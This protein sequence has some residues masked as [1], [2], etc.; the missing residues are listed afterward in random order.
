MNLSIIREII[1]SKRLT[2]ERMLCAEFMVLK[3]LHE[4]K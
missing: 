1:N 4:N 3:A 2:P